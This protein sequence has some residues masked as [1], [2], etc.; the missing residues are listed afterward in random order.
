MPGIFGV[1]NKGNDDPTFVARTLKAM[2]KSLS[3][4]PDYECS[5]WSGKWCGFGHIG[6]PLAGED[7]FIVDDN[8]KGASF[9]GYIYRYKNVEDDLA[10]P[11]KNKAVR[12]IEIHDRYGDKLPE[13]IDGSY[14]AVVI[15]F[16]K[17]EVTIYPDRFAN[18]I[19]F[20]YD[21]SNVFLFSCEYKAFLGCDRFTPKIE[22]RALGDFFNF[23][24][25]NGNR[26]WYKDVN[27]LPGGQILSLKDGKTSIN[28]YWDFNYNADNHYDHNDLIEEAD[29]LYS[30]IIKRQIGNGGDV[31]IPL[32]GGL[33]SRFIAAHTIR[34]GFNPYLF[35]HGKY[36]C[37]DHLL[38]QMVA[39]SLG[40]DRYR[41]IEI[42]PL[43]LIKY[44]DRFVHLSEG[45]IAAH[46]SILYGI[47]EQYNLP[48]K[49]SVF[50]NGIF[51]G[52]GNFGSVFINP[53]EMVTDIPRE[54]KIMHLKNSLG[55]KY[56]DDFF[57]GVFTGEVAKTIR[58][59]HTVSIDEVLAKCEHLSE[60]FCFQKDAFLIKALGN[61]QDIVD[62]HRFIWHDH[63]ALVHDDLSDF[64][65]KIPMELHPE[66]TLLKKY[67][68]AKF[69]D[70]ARIPY[71][72]TGVDLYSQPSA[73]KAKVRQRI[74]RYKY[75][76]ERLSRGHLKF[77][78][79][80]NYV[81][82]DQW[83]RTHKEI[84]EFFEDH[85]LEAKTINR[86]YYNRKNVEK[87]LLR[88]KRGGDSFF[89]LSMLLTFELFNR[90]F[91]DD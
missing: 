82:R 9:A 62:C 63:F 50:L 85:L 6:F 2:E 48:A 74:N 46:R 53:Q 45:L 39:K 36:G 57:Y 65:L 30:T 10:T 8:H 81:H 24:A 89:H 12:L 70:L 60:Y 75:L 56:L 59:N 91:F 23:G 68:K 71:Q 13:K 69:P 80:K 26:T 54:Q 27:R 11:I 44:Y 90:H 55:G 76:V 21:D 22:A 47:S 84:R 64:Y 28:K 38:G 32:S 78:N 29:S 41:F 43:W 51:G 17:R 42:D 37:D 31:I 14:T 34:A 1:V 4:Y 33:D 72:S 66:R 79:R 18:R 20:Y 16:P 67:F 7:R 40:S 86:G 58:D 77:Y 52:P 19:L 5:S 3:H 61:R 88:Q 49:T 15:D 87:V 83:Y 25:V 35:T 73:L